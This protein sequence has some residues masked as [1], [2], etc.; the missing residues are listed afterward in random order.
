MAQYDN[1]YEGLQENKVVVIQLVSYI[2]PLVLIPLFELVIIPL[3]PKIEYFL[4]NPLKGFDLAYIFVII[5]ILTFSII[6]IIARKSFKVPCITWGASDP[7]IEVSFWILVIPYVLA[8]IS[9]ILAHLCLFEFLCSQAPFG[10]LGMII[11]LFLFFDGIS[12]DIGS[13]I[14][15]TFQYIFL[16]KTCA[17]WFTI[18]FCVIAVVG[19]VVYA[20]VARWY[21]KRVRLQRY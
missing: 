17:S 20:L 18:I 4:I 16:S 8:G 15:L 9:E 2:T 6:N 3:A 11:G 21:V 5:S 12:F 1:G 10:M 13:M 19:L 14:V 7:A